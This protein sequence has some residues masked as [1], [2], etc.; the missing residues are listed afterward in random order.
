MSK[1]H[2]P[3]T[4]Q[5]W[6]LL[7]WLRL[8]P[9]QRPN[10]Q[11]LSEAAEPRRAELV[12]RGLITF[13]GGDYVITPAGETLLKLPVEVALRR[14]YDLILKNGYV[15]N[16][17][18]TPEVQAALVALGDST[19]LPSPKPRTKD[20]AA[21]YDLVKWATGPHQG[22]DPFSHVPVLTAHVALFGKAKLPPLASHDKAQ[23]SAP[24]RTS[25]A[26]LYDLTVNGIYPKDVYERLRE[27]GNDPEFDGD[28]MS[29]IW[30]YH[31]KPDRRVFVYR[32][33]PAAVAYRA[34][35]NGV[36]PIHSGDWITLTKEYA[37]EHARD[38][39]G[40]GRDGVVVHKRVKAKEVFTDGNSLSEWGYDP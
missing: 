12:K 31:N 10:Y 14:L 19:A 25:N 28:S 35:L 30:K 24:E 27:Y 21:L 5:D 36:V 9:D 40:R 17:T 1:I 33:V 13:R 2:P 26:P 3:L 39:D 4:E 32:A 11:T 37:K 15:R 23:H 18:K 8:P 7:S 29:V 38:L 16:P 34:R 6:F 20:A 22:G